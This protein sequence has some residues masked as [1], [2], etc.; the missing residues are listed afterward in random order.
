MV[1]KR[2]LCALALGLAACSGGGGGGGIPDGGLGGAG[3]SGT[4]GS[5]TGGTGGAPGCPPGRVLCGDTCVDTQADPLHCASC[6][7][8]CATGDVCANGTCQTIAD[9]SV[10]PCVGL[11]YCQLATKKCLP[12]CISPDQC[13][14][15]EVCNI[16]THACDCAP[17]QHRCGGV[18][19]PDDSVA[20]CGTACSVCP[21]DPN[22]TAACSLG[23]CTLSCNGGFHA[24]NGTCTPNDN[25][26]SCGASC[27]PCAGVPNGTAVCNSGQCGIACNSG[28]HSCNGTCVSDSSPLSCG[29]S[30]TPCP[31]KVGATASCVAGECQYACTN[32]ATL[33]SSGAY[34][35]HGNPV[36]VALGDV[37]GDGNIDAVVAGGSVSVHAGAGNGTFG[38]YVPY[39]L[40]NT[41]S[42]AVGDISGD[43]NPDV[44][45]GTGQNCCLNPP[46][47]VWKLT[48]AGGTLS[49]PVQLASM[50]Y[51]PESVFLEDFSGDGKL[52]FVGASDGSI[53]FAPG[54]GN[55]TFA[56]S[57]T[58]SI[59]GTGWGVGEVT[60]DT[61]PDL[62]VGAYTQVLVLPGSTSVFGTQVGTTVPSA[63]YSVA[64]GDL[65]GDGSADVLLGGAS[66]LSVMN[67]TGAGSLAA[68][69][70]LSGAGGLPVVG[71]FNDD[72]HPDVAQISS[73]SIY[74]RLSNA[75]G[76]LGAATLVAN[77]GGTRAAASDLDGD[78]FSDLVV[79]RSSTGA[80][81]YIYVYRSACK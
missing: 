5:S 18:C 51:P 22:G 43:G 81:N 79:A 69:T 32:G 62:V 46:R 8:Q 26:A 68:P 2:V 55:G 64:T 15:G 33:V 17:G 10:T 63:S 49:T 25:P 65:S 14:T 53:V 48:Q 20:A 7:N 57:Q 58:R 34:V 23:Q 12:G 27:T 54:N 73:T 78:G 21:Q 56:S 52:D 60:G 44:I 66:A 76:S 61:R 75:S 41:T 67:S 1:V 72:G 37:T 9:C 16:A 29:T 3:A 50:A 70:T 24:C 71:D 30:C 35:A 80:T 42:V 47:A 40:A 36:D 11:T 19:V 4:G 28:Y 39:P 45:A 31:A 77:G 13:P 6:T 38:S 59:N 74:L